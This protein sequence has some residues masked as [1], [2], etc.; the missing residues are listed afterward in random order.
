MNIWKILFFIS[1]VILLLAGLCLVFPQE[2]LAFGSRR[3]FFPSLEEVM[4]REKSQSAG[5]KMQAMEES[6]RLQFFMDSIASAKQSAHEDSLR[7]YTNFFSNHPSRIDLPRNNPAFFDPF[8]EELG[9]C[10]E[11]GELLHIL[12]YGDSQIEGDRITGFFRQQ[13]QERFGGKGPG[14]IPAVQPIPSAA[15]GQTASEDIARFI[16]AGSHK[17]RSGHRRYGVLGQVAQ[18]YGGGTITVATRNWKQTFE[19]VKEFSKVRLFVAQ[20]SPGFEAALTLPGGEEITRRIESEKSGISVLTWNFRKPVKKFTLRF[21][22]SAE[23]TGISLDGTSGITVDNIPL[24]GS[25]GTFFKDIDPS[26]LVPVMKELNVRLILLE[27]GG[28]MIPSIKG[29]K[30]IRDYKER[31]SAQI[32][33]FTEIYPQ[34]RLILIGPADMSTKV[35]GKLQTHPMLPETVQA[36]REA[37]LENGAAFWDM[38]R[39]MGGE[40]SMIEWVNNK[41]SLAA[42]DYIHFTPR[43]ADKIAGIFYESLMIYYDHYCF[44]NGKQADE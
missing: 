37:A 38:Y 14:L 10:A 9:S 29:D 8:F 19:H 5:E 40:N 18:V 1:L 16:V 44:L 36:L 21:S 32:R 31:M 43:G 25:S 2:G 41:P 33:Y 28:N 20:N 12:H 35:A 42:P 24:R 13:L 22:G 23:V 30:N 17:N 4:V 34:A 7:F 6:L 15:V 26:S 39:V 27:F 3:L 11:R